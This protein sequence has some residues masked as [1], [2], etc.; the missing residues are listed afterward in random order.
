MQRYL[1]DGDFRR[2]ALLDSL[3]NPNNVYA[4]TRIESYG[5]KDRGWEQLPEWTPKTQ[6][7]DQDYVENLRSGGPVLLDATARP[8]WDGVRPQG[9]AAWIAL[10]RRVFYQYPLR[11]EIFADHALRNPALAARIGLAPTTAGSWPGVI[12]FED[13]EG[14]AVIGITCALCH[15]SI[16]AGEAVEGRARRDFDYGEM[17]LAFY[18]DTDATISEDLMRRMA[19][20]GPGRADITQDDQEDPVAIVDLWG[21]VDHRF[22]TQSGTIRHQHPAALAIR[23]ESQIIHANEERIRPPRVLTWALAMYLYSLRPP[24]RTAN[25]NPEQRTRGREQFEEHCSHCHSDKSYGGHIVS[26][27][28]IGTDPALASGQARGTGF[29]RPSPLLAV[30]QAGPY[31]HDGTVESLESLLDPARAVPGHRYGDTLPDD[32]KSD[33]LVF[34]RSL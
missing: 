16:E 32:D 27:E 24:D 6:E 14:E 7:I 5:L 3:T 4:R 17:R 15:V 20:W 28:H 11:A 30:A 18:R 29:Y 2:S 26:V 9:Q 22:L 13:I 25:A 10:G 33:L 12:A 21:L 23:Q 19:S 8:L 31:L 1:S 34:L